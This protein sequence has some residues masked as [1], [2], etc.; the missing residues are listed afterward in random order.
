MKGT[1]NYNNNNN[2]KVSQSLIFRLTNI[3]AKNSKNSITEMV[4]ESNGI[5]IMQ[6]KAI[7]ATNL[8]ASLTTKQ[9]ESTEVQAHFTRVNT[10]R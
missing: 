2:D 3:Q 7:L 10:E 4:N 1:N 8:H 6:S 9:Q 5:I